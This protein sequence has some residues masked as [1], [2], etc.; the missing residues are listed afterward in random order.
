VMVAFQAYLAGDMDLAA[1]V[2]AVADVAAGE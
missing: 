1:C 2:K